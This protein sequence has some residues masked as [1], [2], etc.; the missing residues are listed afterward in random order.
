MKKYIAI[1]SAAFFILVAVSVFALQGKNVPVQTAQEV[2]PKAAD[3]SSSG[4]G[5]NGSGCASTAG[6]GGASGGC[7]G[8]AADPAEAKLLTERLTA[9]LT[10]YYTTKRG[11]DSVQVQIEDFGCHQEATVTADGQ[12]V[13]KL[14]ISGSRITRIE[15]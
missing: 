15:S 8:E 13:D 4:C 3:A 11:Y 6:C 12:L 5:V 14:S 9:Y 2:Q 7:S 10:N 1:G